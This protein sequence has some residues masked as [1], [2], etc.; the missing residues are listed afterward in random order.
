MLQGYCK[1]ILSSALHVTDISRRMTFL[2]EMYPDLV[3][4][5]GAEWCG[6]LT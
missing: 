1:K 5:S 3:E 4:A 2:T 6:C